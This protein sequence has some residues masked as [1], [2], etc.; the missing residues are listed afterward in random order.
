MAQEDTRLFAKGGRQTDKNE[1]A[2]GRLIILGLEH[3]CNMKHNFGLTTCPLDICIV[4][5]GFYHGTMALILQRKE[6]SNEVIRHTN[7]PIVPSLCMMYGGGR[8]EQLRK[9]L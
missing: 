4:S 5:Y 9:P 7:A 1:L 2:S 8:T 3:R 6:A